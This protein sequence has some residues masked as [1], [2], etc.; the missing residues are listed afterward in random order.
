MEINILDKFQTII[1]TAKEN[2]KHYKI[3]IMEPFNMEKNMEKEFKLLE[4]NNI[5]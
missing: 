3:Y 1:L 4:N 2:Q 5:L